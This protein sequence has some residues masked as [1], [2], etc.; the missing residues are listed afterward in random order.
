MKF[1]KKS[2]AAIFTLLMT[3]S[4]LASCSAAPEK[5][6][7]EKKTYE[8]THEQIIN[9]FYE[10]HKD[11]AAGLMVGVFDKNGTVYEGYYGYSN[12]AEGIKVDENTVI[13]W[14]STTK[15]MVW[16]SV[17][18]LW[19]KEKIDLEKDVREYLPEGFLKNL[20]YD[21]P[22]RMLDLMN[23]R[24]GF[25]EYYTDMFLR[26]G[27]KF[28]TLEEALKLDQPEQVFEPD[29]ITAYSNWGVSLAAYIVERI[30]GQS[31]A[32][33]VH[34]HI[35][36]P[37]GM[38]DSALA[39]DLMD[40]PG[41][42]ERRDKLVCYQGIVPVGNAFYYISMY[43]AGAC[44]STL[45]DYI[46]YGSCFVKDKFPLFERQETFDVMMSATSY[47]ADT[48]TARNAHGF[49]ALP[50]GE[51]VYGHGGNTQACSSYITFDLKTKIG[52]VVMT[53]QAGEQN[54]NYE[55]F[56]H[57]YG[58]NVWEDPSA[59]SKVKDGFY[60]PAR[61]VLKG[62]FQIMGA[63]YLSKDSFKEWYWTYNEKDGIPKI[64]EMYGDYYLASPAH[65][66]F[67]CVL[68][69]GW[70]ISL[71]FAFVSLIV[72]GIRAIV[73]K[74]KKSTKKIVLGVQT[75]FMSLIILLLGLMGLVI[76]TL[77]TM[78]FPYQTYTWAFPTCGVLAVV[79]AVLTALSLVKFFKT[80]AKESS[81]IRKIYNI[82][83]VLFSVLN[84]VFVIY[85]N[86]WH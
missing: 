24:A 82:I 54:F 66:V 38:N 11:T 67:E 47:F 69:Y 30:S 79:L 49:W 1:F 26:V 5:K 27:S 70:A 32:D 85:L 33:Y 72:K 43:P 58:K 17:M 60:H 81:V 65:A 63:S 51:A 2:A 19:E 35:F 76:M 9:A 34:E 14:G 29:T 4:L 48:K 64:E 46:K 45:G 55:M 42:R 86:L 59:E 12:V 18:Q 41:V 3:L 7:E 62:H 22:V 73:R 28:H 74:A 78:W 36:K 39:P 13:D 61:S 77:V 53:N 6:E 25:Q 20:R 44:V 10:D 50:Y 37:L 21:K 75:G 40:N 83:A 56:N 84:V 8:G 16:V 52:C 57:I 80:P 68:I 23:H 31:F 15:T 71:V